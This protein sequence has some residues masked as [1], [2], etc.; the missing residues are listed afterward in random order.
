MSAYQSLFITRLLLRRQ[1][2]F[3]VTCS[4]SPLTGQGHLL[5]KRRWYSSTAATSTPSHLF[6]PKPVNYPYEVSLGKI[7]KVVAKPPGNEKLVPTFGNPHERY[8]TS[9]DIRHLEWMVKKELMKQDMFLIGP[10]G[11][12]KRRLV[13]LYGYIMSREMEMVQISRDTTEADIK[14]RREI[15]DKSVIYHDQV[16]IRR[17]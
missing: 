1:R 12:Y 2:G 11:G 13:K 8:L 10:P 15:K 6:P 7:S 9:T 3:P 16:K 14:Q 5:W 17:I 4:S